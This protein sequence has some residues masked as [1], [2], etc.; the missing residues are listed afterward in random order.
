LTACEPHQ[1]NECRTLAEPIELHYDVTEED[2]AAAA[3][4][5]ERVWRDSALSGRLVFWLRVLPLSAIVFAILV[6]IALVRD[7]LVKR[8][9]VAVFVALLIA[10]ACL[11]V[12]WLTVF[13]RM[14]GDLRGKEPFPRPHRLVLDDDGISCSNERGSTSFKWLNFVAIKEGDKLITLVTNRR[15]CVFV[16]VRAFRA[17]EARREFLSRAQEKIAANVAAAG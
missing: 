7:G 14:I 5:E 16:P 4:I 6:T 12:L 17:D 9:H 15:T 11:F 10:V 2:L 13:D 3:K 1:S 8:G